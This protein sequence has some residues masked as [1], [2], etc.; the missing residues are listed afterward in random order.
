MQV[1]Y[2]SQKP[3][4]PIV[5]GGSFAINRL[6]LDLDELVDTEIDYLSITTKK[7]PISIDSIPPQIAKNIT[8]HAVELDTSIKILPLLSSF[9]SAL[10]FNL[11]RYKQKEFIGKIKELALSK[12]YNF[13]L[14]DGFYT[15]AYLHELRTLTDAK[16]IYRSHNI[17][18]QIWSELAGITTNK[19]KRI[20]LNIL[21][22]KVKKYEGKIHEAVDTIAAICQTDAD[23]F[24]S[25]ATSKVQVIPVSILPVKPAT[26]ITNNELCF[27]GNFNWFPNV[28]GISWFI[29]NVFST[30]KNEYPNITLHIAGFGSR[31]SLAA[32]NNKGIVIHGAIDDVPTFIKSHGIFISPIFY[33]SGIKIKV[34]EAMNASV[35]VVLSKKSAEGINFPNSSSFFI[36]KEEA[37]TQLKKLLDNPTENDANRMLMSHIIKTQFTQDI[38][39]DKLKSILH[40]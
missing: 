40:E 2:I 32:Y 10:P 37:Y 36:T 33:G 30:L 22:K 13:I 38:V 26:T 9:F 31:E 15:T 11:L 17:E 4:F 19:W 29:D 34:L 12:N 3:A 8:I 27:I 5:D 25:F 7:H 14:L 28:E 1:L 35:P 21:A 23:Y 39:I 24:K 16:I 20:F 6:L 18:N